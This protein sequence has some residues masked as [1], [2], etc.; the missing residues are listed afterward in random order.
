MKV[1]PQFDVEIPVPPSLNNIYE[2]LSPHKSRKT[3]KVITGRR[4]SN[5]Y[6]AWKI[7]AAWEIARAVPAEK[8][9]A[10]PVTVAI[11]LP[12]KMRGD[13]DNR[14]KGALDALV[15]SGRIDDDRNVVQ[16]TAAKRLMGK[17]HAFISVKGIG[18][19]IKFPRS[20]AA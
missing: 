17:T 12:E 5:E 3:G 20:E 9:I 8:R 6:E 2:N 4:K 19:L 11:L 14:I 18:S 1:L 13:I 15:A 16:V 10:G 7:A